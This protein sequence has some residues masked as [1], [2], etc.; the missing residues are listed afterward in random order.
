MKKLLLPLACLVNGVYDQIRERALAMQF[1]VKMFDVLTDEQWERMQD[2]VDH[3]PEYINVFLKKVQENREKN[4][5][6][7]SWQPGVDSW[8]PGD[9]I[10][11]GYRWERNTRGGFPRGQ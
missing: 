5:R 6:D 9:A 2:L 8:R 4:A 11:E 1:K 10:P 7:A 3:P